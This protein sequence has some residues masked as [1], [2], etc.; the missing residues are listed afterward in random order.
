M[1]FYQTV[2]TQKEKKKTFN[3]EKI[4]INQIFKEGGVGRCTYIILLYMDRK[5]KLPSFLLLEQGQGFSYEAL[6]GFTVE[7]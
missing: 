5:K 4:I 3:K 7:K 2:L 6:K 1:R